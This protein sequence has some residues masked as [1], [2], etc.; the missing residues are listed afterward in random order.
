MDRQTVRDRQTD[1]WV[2]QEDGLERKY[3]NQQKALKMGNGYTHSQLK[4]RETDK[5]TCFVKNH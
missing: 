4:K 2:E 3:K 5:E 1:N